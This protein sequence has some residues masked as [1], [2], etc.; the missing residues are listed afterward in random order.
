MSLEVVKAGLHDSI[1]DIGRFGYQHLGINPSGAM[2]CI[3]MNIANALVGNDLNEAVIELCFPAA[4]L[5]F[6]E[7]AFIS[8][9][10]ANFNA[11]LNGT[12]VPLHHLIRVPAGAILKFTK[13][14]NGSFCYLAIRG[15]FQLEDWLGS[16][17]T[18]TKVKAGGWN[19]R[20]LQKGD[21]ISF[22]SRIH[23]QV[24]AKVYPWRAKLTD[25]YSD[26]KKNI[27]A[28][29]GNEF[30]W[31]GKTSQC[32][33][34]KETFAISTQS[35]RMGYP[36]QGKELKQTTKK[37]LL[38]TAVS[39]GTVQ[40]LPNGQLIVL[41]ADH[42]TTGGYPRVAQVIRAD[43]G[44]FV[45]RNSR[46]EISFDFIALEDAERLLKNQQRCMEQL[47]L[48]CLYKLRTIAEIE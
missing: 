17:S 12:S 10:G 37:Q 32:D 23:E 15:G 11:T 31:L 24:D 22:R 39:F 45:Q 21:N 34:T 18:N 48:S 1:Q 47:R 43:L 9:S 44:T 3:A 35:D 6:Q 41:C 5:V 40:L 36:L 7:A 16:R 8:L 30:D 14:L 25:F 33:L 20:I 46:E 26:Q 42:Q 27:R 28:L 38:S 29:Q 4:Q 19:G 13:K 2:D